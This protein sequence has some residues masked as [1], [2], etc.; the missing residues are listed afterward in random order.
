MPPDKRTEPTDEEI[1]FCRGN[2]ISF[3]NETHP[4]IIVALGNVPLKWLTKKSG[5]GDK[6][7]KVYE[8]PW[9]IVIP[10]YHPS[11]IDRNPDNERF[12][13]EDIGIAKEIA[14]N[15]LESY[16]KR[17]KSSIDIKMIMSMQ[18]IEELADKL[19]KAKDFSFDIETT[20]LQYWDELIGIGFAMDNKQG[21]Y[22]PFIDYKE[23]DKKRTPIYIFTEKERSQIAGLF[24]KVFTVHKGWVYA[25][26]AKF[27]YRKL[28]YDWKLPLWM[29]VFDTMIGH[30][31]ID[32]NQPHDLKSITDT[33]FQDMRGYNQHLENYK[34]KHR[35]GKTTMIGIP[36]EIMAFYCA[37]DSIACYRLAHWLNSNLSEIA[38]KRY[39][40][41]Y[42]PLIS[43]YVKSELNGISVDWEYAGKL[44]KVY[45][46]RAKNFQKKVYEFSGEVFNINSPDQLIKILY[47]K[48][49]FPVLGYTKKV[50]KPS[51]G[52]EILIKLSS[53]LDDDRI[54]IIKYIVMYK[55]MMKFVSTYINSLHNCV[56]P[57]GRIHYSYK[58]ILKTGRF[59]CSHYPIQTIPR[60]NEVRA[61]F[62]ARDGWTLVHGDYSQLELRQAATF[63]GSTEMLEALVN[64]LDLHSDLAKDTF[65]LKD[66]SEVKKW[67]RYVGKTLGFGIIYLGE[68]PTLQNTI[69]K[70]IFQ[71]IILGNLPEDTPLIDLDTVAY[72]R[73]V[74][75][76]KHPHLRNWLSKMR[77]KVLKDGQ[78]VSIY[79]LV[80][81]LPNTSSKDEYLREEA[82]RMGVNFFIQSPSSDI[83]QTA[84]KKLGIKIYKQKIPVWLLDFS[85]HDS[86]FTEVKKEGD[87]PEKCAKYMKRVMLEPVP[88]NIAILDVDMKISDRWAEIPQKILD[89]YELIKDQRK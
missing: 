88:P 60:E 73:S 66:I 14:L 53:Q 50:K 18:E 69:N 72:G 7:G 28:Y 42:L 78:S 87:L 5:I 44:K 59:S 13:K 34:T 52:I 71:A 82:L 29:K 75:F 2:V 56:G 12:L 6:R 67:Q 33:L 4:K 21:Y 61:L 15:G 83:C 30:F 32:E 37:A 79:G 39:K 81:H 62:K 55:K 27:D 51:T 64:K 25:H 19:I 58:L 35:I 31:L 74:Y 3:L 76:K 86:I 63:S 8:T 46:N 43:I 85:I 16:M 20:G 38:M 77:M 10:T 22:I 70:G 17:S 24:Q 9:G 57:D 54:G 68:P 84:Y 45:L 11:N 26:N 48:F 80:R 1:E 23:D 36:K 49:K 89:E 41:F 65:K 40:E 47:D